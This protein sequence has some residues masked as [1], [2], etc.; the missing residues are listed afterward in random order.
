[1]MTQ[2][3]VSPPPHRDTIRSYVIRAGRMT[4]AQARALASQ[5]EGY[6]LTLDSND[7]L[8]PVLLFSRPAPLILDIGFGMGEAL[9]QMAAEQSH[10][11]FMGV[12]VHRPGVGALLL[13][14]A[15]LGI[16][17]IR[18]FS[19]DANHVLNRLS[20]ASLDRV[21]LFFPDPWHKKRHHKRRLVQAPFLTLVAEKLKPDGILHVATD[22]QPYAEEI[23]DHLQAH[24]SFQPLSQSQAAQI[25]AQRPTTKFE[26][27]GKRRGHGISDILYQRSLSEH[28]LKAGVARRS[29][30]CGL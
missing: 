4:P 24:A 11:N 3:K 9:L 26:R 20:P 13:Q 10:V 18:V 21:Q 16:E 5:A 6:L 23:I 22:W 15:K 12:E 30:Q 2:D 29:M 19:A 27:R 25:I 17:N 28:W 8:D 14:R 1:M 7:F